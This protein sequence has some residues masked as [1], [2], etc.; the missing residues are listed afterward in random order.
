MPRYRVVFPDNPEWAPLERLARLRHPEL[1]RI[2]PGEFLY[3]GMLS[4][5]GLPR[6]H[7]YKHSTTRKYLNLDD[8]GH[9]YRFTGEM[10]QEGQ[11]S[12]VA[13]YELLPS[14]RHALGG[15]SADGQRRQ[16]GG[17]TGS[18]GRHTGPTA[19]ERGQA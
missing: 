2:D 15:D 5:R 10:W 17:P 16:P 12:L 4:R 7:L 19:V 14:L 18:I 11:R 13:R 8:N 1:P 6:V 3:M 9:A